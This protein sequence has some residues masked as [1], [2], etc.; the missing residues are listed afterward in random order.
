VFALWIDH[1]VRPRDAQYAY[2]IVPGTDAKQLAEWVAHPPVRII[3]NT[4]A[5]QAV[6][7]D[8]AGVAEIAF[9]TPGSVALTPGLTIK[10]DQPCLVLAAKHGNSTRVVVSGPGGEVFTVHLTIT[11]PR[12]E[13]SVT[14][15]LPDGDRAGKSQ[16][17]DVPVRW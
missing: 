6:I 16:V 10:V 7:N 1:G 15:A 11:T 13:R 12:R 5:Q 8:H 17:M 2:A 14:F 9:Y 3:T 4:I